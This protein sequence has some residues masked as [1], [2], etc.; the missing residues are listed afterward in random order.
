MDIELS[1]EEIE[2]ILDALNF[3]YLNNSMTVTM[4]QQVEYL[5]NY[6]EEL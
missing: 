3:Y 2:L 6:L 4:K 1:E 5:I